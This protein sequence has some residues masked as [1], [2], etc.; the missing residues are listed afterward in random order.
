MTSSFVLS[1][2]GV[3]YSCN[4]GVWRVAAEAPHLNEKSLILSDFNNTPSG[5]MTVDSQP[6]FA[7][8]VI[9]KHLRSEGLIDGEA[10]VQTHRIIS[11]GGG[12]RVMYTAVPI[13]LWQ[14]TFTWLN[15]QSSVGLLYS[16]DAA[17]L[18]LAQNYDAI[19][20]RIGRQFRFLVSGKTTLLYLSITA[21]SDDQDDLDTALQNLLNQVRG[22]WNL[23]QEALDVYWCDLLAPNIEADTRFHL[24]SKQTLGVNVVVAPT[25]ILALENGQIRTCAKTMLE[26]VSWHKACNTWLDRITGALDQFS[27]PIAAA[28][29]VCGLVLFAAVGMLMVETQSLKDQEQELKA[30][31]ENIDKMNAGFDAAPSELLKPYIDTLTFLDNLSSAGTSQDPLALLL[32]LRIASE[33]RVRVM[34][35]R[36]LPKNEGFRV[37]GV[38][39]NDSGS[40]N[41]MS[42]FLSA[43][44]LKGYQLKAE[45]P[46][47]QGT[48]AGYFSYSIRRSGDVKAVKL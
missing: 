23:R 35:V 5:V 34:R 16:V 1:V 19:I 29:A 47:N 8:A 18:A 10:H 33:Q 46:G 27:K 22:Q 4:D 42:G 39:V 9:E 17:M 25:T 45:D 6:D 7:A 38:P 13:A 2:N 44:Y 21:F 11:A 28:A 48:Q 37:D 24:M 36:L 30:N 32:D 20:C 15:S 14:S 40:D 26:A 41:A 43:L 3:W 31:I 12:S